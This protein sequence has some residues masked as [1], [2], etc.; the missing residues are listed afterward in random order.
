MQR[1]HAVLESL[2]NKD[3]VYSLDWSFWSFG[4]CYDKFNTFN[5][6]LYQ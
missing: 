3:S 6:H 1:A 2:Y 4:N 5:K